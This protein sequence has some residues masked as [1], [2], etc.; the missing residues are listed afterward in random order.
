MNITTSYGNGDQII[1]GGL[2]LG[3]NSINTDIHDTS[4]ECGE[5]AFNGTYPSGDYGR[6]F[7]FVINGRGS[8]DKKFLKIAGLRCIEGACPVPQMNDGILL[9]PEYRL[10]SNPLSWE[11]A[12]IPEDGDDV[13]IKA[14]WNMLLDVADPPLI[15]SLT[16]NGRLTFK[17][18]NDLG[19]ITFRAKNIWVQAGQFYIGTEEEPFINSAKV[20]LVGM[21]DDP[22]IVISGGIEAGNKVLINSGKVK[23]YGQERVNSNMTRLTETVFAEQNY[24]KVAS[25]LNWLSGDKLYFAPTTMQ[26]DQSD[27][28]TIDSYDQGTGDLVL[29]ENF[30][31]YHWGQANAPT[32]EEFGGLDMRGEVILLSRNIQIIGDDTDGWGCSVLTA[33]LR[34]PNDSKK[35]LAGQMILDSVEVY[36]CSQRNTDHAAIRFEGA[37]TGP[38]EIRNI[39][40]HGSMA[41]PFYVYSSNNINVKDSSFIGGRQV[42]ANLRSISNVHLQGVFV[43]DIRRRDE[44]SNLDGAV[45]KEACFAF[46][47]IW[48]PNPC[49]DSSITNS[50]AAGCMYGGFVAPGHDCGETDSIKFRDNV[51][52][53]IAGAGAYIYPDP[54]VAGHST[55]YE[56]SHFSAYKNQE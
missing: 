4:L 9:E 14:T 55:C 52:H 54:A 10:W 38:S 6:E 30:K 26:Q 47:S 7:N 1:E 22:T 44:I 27:Y 21:Q 53:S 29:T 31:F 36:N 23:F 12:G 13:E 5:N 46:C 32:A 51:A 20:I 56:G 2:R 25:G 28:L 24:A 33:E 43:A 34:D 15:N 35:F 49:Y 39:A 11:G 17:N 18:D 42:G 41:W 3:D 50:I 40:V 48:E 45:D 16:I 8:S 37:I 19:D